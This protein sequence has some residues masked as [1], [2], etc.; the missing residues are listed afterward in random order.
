MQLAPGKRAYL[1]YQLEGKEM[2]IISTF[3]PPEFRGRGI[4][5]SLMEAALR[6]AEEMGYKVVP[7]CDYAKHYMSKKGLLS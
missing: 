7:V 1:T 5:A 4:A 2:R 3:T 6:F